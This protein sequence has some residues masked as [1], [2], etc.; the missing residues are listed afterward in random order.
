MT[1]DAGSDGTIAVVDGHGTKYFS[2]PANKKLSF[3]VGGA[4]G[5]H[6]V[7]LENKKGELLDV[8]SFPV[9]CKTG[10]SDE[11]GE[12]SNLLDM[13]YYTMNTGHTTAHHRWNGKTYTTFAGW[14]QDHVHVFK[15]MKY[16]YAD[17]K[18]GIDLFADG[19]RDDGMIYDNYYNPYHTYTSWLNR[20]GEKFVKVPDDPKLNSSF[21]VRI[22][23]ENMSEFTFLEGVYYVWKAT[24]D[25]DWM[26]GRLDNCINAIEYSTSDAYRWSKKFKLLKRGYTIDIWDF[27]PEQDAAQFGGDFMMADPEKSKFGVM[28]GDNI[29]IAV[30]C[31]Y[32]A[33]MLEY[34]GRKQDATRIASIGKDIRKRTDE[35]CWN[36]QFYT[37]H[38]PED[39]SYKHDFGGTDESKQVTVSNA[40]AINRRIGH[41]KAAAII[42]TYQRIAKEM[43]ESSPGEWYLCY[44]PF[45]KGWHLEKWE[46]MNGGVSSIVAGE[47]A[48]G[49]FEHGFEAYGVHVLRRMGEL[50][51][52]TGNRLECIY[53]GAM[54]DK[55]DRKFTPL[56]LKDIANADTHGIGAEGVPGWTNEGENDLHEF[57]VG[58]QVFQD[59]PFDFVDPAEN[60]RRA[61]LI[62]SGDKQYVLKRELPVN[63]KA[64]SIYVVHAQSYGNHIGNITLQYSDGSSYVKYI[65]R[66]ENIA[67]WWYPQDSPYADGHYRYK[68]A[69]R[70]KNKRCIDVGVFIFGF[71]NP[72]AS[73]IIRSI[74]FNGISHGGKISLSLWQ[75]ASLSCA[76]LRPLAS[77]ASV[78][79]TP[80]PP[81]S[82]MMAS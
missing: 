45:E 18:S 9:D 21:F 78:A 47:V 37:H 14:F 22:P 16:F 1:L 11:K 38:I 63:I 79:S 70:G 33:E 72:D 31:D 49:A 73:K 68:V 61:C 59:V 51:Q 69:W 57:P 3:A 53:R 30:G 19:Q 58:R 12:F 15:A 24:G 56:S 10:I 60:G 75:V 81:V 62:L 64:A 17:V 55:P 46:Y 48:H 54:P 74:G 41:E 28:Y 66:G 4:L 6:V 36:G 43:P 5:N 42:R 71:N 32:V 26:G 39:P 77:Q 35:L 8:A 25:D 2:A 34:A 80:S 76:I 13:L 29:G 65:T 40:Y 50:A 67:G 82:V 27:L 23:V 44:P 20:F 52:L 7:L